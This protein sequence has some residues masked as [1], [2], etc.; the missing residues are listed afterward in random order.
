MKEILMILNFRDF[1]RKVEIYFQ[2]SDVQL[3]CPTVKEDIVWPVTAG[4]C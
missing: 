3:F 4:F 2:N 1:R